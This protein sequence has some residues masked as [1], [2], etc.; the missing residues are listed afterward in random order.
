MFTNFTFIF[1][2]ASYDKSRGY[3]QIISDNNKSIII[4]LV[5][6]VAKYPIDVQT[7]KSYCC[8]KATLCVHYGN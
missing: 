4:I 7:I 5:R 6:K 3:V 2:Y 8:L 1:Q